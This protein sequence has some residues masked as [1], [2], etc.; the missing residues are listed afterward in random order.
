MSSPTAALLAALLLAGCSGK[1]AAPDQGSDTDEGSP[2]SGCELPGRLAVTLQTR[3][4]VSLSA[5]HYPAAAG[6]P[7]VVLL[8]MHPGGNDRTNWPCGFIESLQGRDWAV[9][10]PDRRGTGGSGGEVEDAFQGEFGRYDVEAAVALLSKAEVGPMAVLGAS[11]GT[12][13][14]IDYLVWAPGE[15]LAQ[16]AAS[17][18]LSG[19]AYTENQTEMS[20]VAALGIPS[21]FAYPTSEAQWADAQAARAVEGWSFLEYPEG[22]HGTR[23]FDSSPGITEDLLTFLAGS[24]ET[25]GPN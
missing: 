2:A 19:G 11:N 21:V 24:L 13:S 17:G 16:A 3:D 14:M 23:L 18:F 1:K 9:V 20:A 6:R 5:D 25:A 8:H 15:G 4:G 7:G 10:V 12:T 22:D